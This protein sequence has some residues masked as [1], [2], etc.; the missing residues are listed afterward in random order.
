MTN[1]QLDTKVSAQPYVFSGRGTVYS[2]TILQEVPAEF[3]EQSPLFL[4]IIQLDEGPLVIGQLTDVD[5]QINIGD[6]VEMVTRKLMTED[7][8]GMIVYGYKFRPVLKRA[9]QS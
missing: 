6:E 2:F 8:R 5:G 1:S 3:E 9:S 7:D 4:G